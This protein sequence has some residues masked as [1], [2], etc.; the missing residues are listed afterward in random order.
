VAYNDFSL[1]QLIKQFSLTEQ[2]TKLF[3]NPQAIEP[4][5]WLQ[6]TLSFSLNIALSS[7]SEKARSEFIIAPILLELK[8]INQKSFNIFSGER[9]N[10]VPEQGLNGACDFILTQGKNRH[11]LQTPIF[12]L[13]E[14]QKNDI[15]EGL[16]QCAAQMLGAKFYNTQEE[17]A[18][19]FIY[20]CVTTGE[21]WQFMQLQENILYI[22]Q[23]RHYINELN[24]LL[25][26]LQSIIISFNN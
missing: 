13:V 21:I 4:S 24:K 14:A 11:T 10:S 17:C 26:I 20:G 15:K 5:N 12:M 7:S 23:E 19:E 3:G 16:G 1:A 2:S 22:D 8:Q 18:P 6:Q 25:W 9:L